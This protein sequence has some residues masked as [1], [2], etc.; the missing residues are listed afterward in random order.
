MQEEKNEVVQTDNTV[1]QDQVGRD[2]VT[3][4]F[5]FGNSQKNISALPILLQKF[6]EEREK[7]PAL[8]KFIEELDYY[9]K[10]IEADV[11]GLEQKLI[12]GKRESFIHYATRVKESFHKKLYR[13]QFSEAA[14]RINYHLLALVESYFMNQVY[15]RICNEEDPNVINQL[16]T[17]SIVTPI[18]SEQL[19]EEPLN[20]SAQEI[21]GMIYFLTGNCHIKWNK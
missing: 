10:P 6:K 19:A 21:N 7:N 17:D 8:D 12:N 15:P 14:Q 9:N 5:N 20:Y 1:G 11:I 4:N 2:K 16:V 13:Y 18:L 3:T